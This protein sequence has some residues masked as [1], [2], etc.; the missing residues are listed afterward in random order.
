MWF[1]RVWVPLAILASIVCVTVYASIQQNYRQSLNDPQ[2]QMAE[3][4][5]RFLENDYTPAALVPRGVAPVD[6]SM[7]LAPWIAVY[8]D[9]GKAL[10]SSAIVDGMP[11][12]PP[13]GVFDAA[14]TNSGKDTDVAGQNRVT[15]QTQSG[16]R[17]AI[18]VQ[19]ITG[20]NGGFVVAGRN[21]REVETRERHVSSM[22]ALAWLAT[23]VATLLAAWA[24]SYFTK[25]R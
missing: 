3:D 25:P 21:M 20:E 4:G 12:Q 13:L 1:F 16:A 22:I 6:G 24:G 18:V 10:E 17:I 9:K 19:H 23:L 8:D 2:I 11:P 5:A 14:L 15:W 7:S